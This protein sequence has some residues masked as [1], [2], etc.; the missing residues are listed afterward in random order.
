MLLLEQVQLDFYLGRV[1]RLHRLNHLP[2]EAFPAQAGEVGLQIGVLAPAVVELE[3]R[4]A[5][6]GMDV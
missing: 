3:F 4:A 2:A 6:P 1:G 5:E